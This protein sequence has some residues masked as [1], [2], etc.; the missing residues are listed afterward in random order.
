MLNKIMKAALAASLVFG[1][2]AGVYAEDS[3]K[4]Y[5]KIMQQTWQTTKSKEQN[6]ASGKASSTLETSLDGTSRLGWMVT[7]GKVSGHVEMALDSGATRLAYASV[8]MGG[9]SLTIGK[10]YT[11]V[12]TATPPGP[13]GKG[14]MAGTF[15][16]NR[17]PMIQFATAGLKVALVEA[18]KPSMAST[19]AVATAALPKIEASYSLKAGP[20]S[21]DVSFG[22]QTWTYQNASK[23]Y[24]LP[25]SIMAALVTMNAGPALVQFNYWMGTN[26]LDYS[27]I[28][29]VGGSVAS[30]DATGDKII[31]GSSTAM[32]LWAK[33]G[34]GKGMDV[35]G[36][37]STRTDDTGVSGAKKS[38]LAQ[39]TIGLAV[40]MDNGLKIQPEFGSLDLGKSSADVKLGNESWVGANLTLEF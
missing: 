7:K 21:V 31:S 13:F 17:K 19:G 9:G 29:P 20:A 34:L 4:I 28:P 38:T 37:Y 2:S 3:S 40:M 23:A 8:P 35:V 33:M 26:S 15:F 14:A 12:L 22:T 27:G 30:Y 16:S 24:S 39:T 11:P 25:S 1:F 18:T 5:G 10:H 36:G 32:M 6:A